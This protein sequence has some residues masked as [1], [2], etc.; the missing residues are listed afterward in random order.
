MNQKVYDGRGPAFPG[1]VQCPNCAH[2][3]QPD[4]I[5]CIVC[6][7][8]CQPGAELSAWKKWASDKLHV[9]STERDLDGYQ[10]ED[11]NPREPYTP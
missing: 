8:P 7:R 5:K 1:L 10:A 6:A 11:I 4:A 9:N 3:N 2:R